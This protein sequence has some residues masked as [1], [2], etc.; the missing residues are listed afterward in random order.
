MRRPQWCE[1]CHPGDL[2][3]A[4]ANYDRV[5]RPF[6]NVI[7]GE[8]RVPDLAA[9]L[10]KEDRGGDWQLIEAPARTSTV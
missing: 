4:S 5:L 10:A 1:A 6:V 3:T 7:Q 9:R 8:L 2:P